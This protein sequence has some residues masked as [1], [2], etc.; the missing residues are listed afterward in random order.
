ME[1]SFEV[2]RRRTDVTDIEVSREKRKQQEKATADSIHNCINTRELLS[3]LLYKT[4]RKSRLIIVK[5]LVTFALRLVIFPQNEKTRAIS[6]HSESWQE[7]E[8]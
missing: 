5:H 6:V 2:P 1:S 7:G 8:M 3:H 4:V